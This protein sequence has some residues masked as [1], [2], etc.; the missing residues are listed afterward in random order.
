MTTKAKTPAI[1]M[2]PVKSSQ[3]ESCAHHGDTLTV[4]FKNGGTYSYHGVSADTFA[5]LNKAE[6]FGSHFA[7][8]IKGGG[9]KFTKH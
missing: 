5:A 7:K 2:N 9:F 1:T 3:V 6:S 8:H 4:K